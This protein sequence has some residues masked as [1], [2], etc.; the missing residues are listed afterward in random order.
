MKTTDSVRHIYALG[1]RT[2]NHEYGIPADSKRELFEDFDRWL[3]A[4]LADAWDS[5]Y[6]NGTGDEAHY[7]RGLSTDPGAD[8]VP[9][10][11]PYRK[12]NQ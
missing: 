8:E 12:V 10:S 1:R 7:A 2:Q 11:N 6:E 3:N 9:H 5:G 4:Q